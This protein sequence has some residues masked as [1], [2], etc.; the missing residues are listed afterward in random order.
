MDLGA[1]LCTRAHASCDHCPV[2]SQCLAYAQQRVKDFPTS[3]PR[4]TLP[5]RRTQL[6]LVRNAA[7]A[8][9]LTKRPPAGIWGGLWSLPECA[10]DDDISDWCRQ[11]LGFD[12]REED[13]WPV[14]RHTFSHFHLDI[15]PVL[16][17]IGAPTSMIMDDA[18]S[19]W[20]NLQQPQQLGLAAPVQRLLNQLTDTRA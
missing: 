5:V 11:R 10:V 7:A 9:L 14:L 13:R 15:H 4:A 16:V 3:K 18:G 12:V 1:T 8:V 17:S 6:L 20:Y 2:H 19:V